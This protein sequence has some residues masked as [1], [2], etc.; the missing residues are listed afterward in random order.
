MTNRCFNLQHPFN[1]YLFRICCL[2]AVQ[3]IN[4]VLKLIIVELI[5]NPNLF[6]HNF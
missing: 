2:V 1:A 5:N 6:P 3:G 4:L